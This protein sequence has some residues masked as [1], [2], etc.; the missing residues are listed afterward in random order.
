[1]G[2]F[3]SGIYTFAATNTNQGKKK[4]K[5][6]RTT[7]GPTTDIDHLKQIEE[8]ASIECEDRKTNLLRNIYTAF[9]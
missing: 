7:M 6:K 1:M 2:A 5:K 8:G 3:E 9:M 4:K